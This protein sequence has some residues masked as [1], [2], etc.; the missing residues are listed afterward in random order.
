M[1]AGARFK[2]GVARRL[3]GSNVSDAALNKVRDNCSPVGTRRKSTY[4]DRAQL[5]VAETGSAG[6]GTWVT[7][8]A[9]V[10]ADFAKAFG[11]WPGTPIQIAVASDTDKSENMARA[12]FADLWFVTSRQLAYNG[13]HGDIE[14]VDGALNGRLWVPK[15]H[16]LNRQR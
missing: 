2:L 1:S 5:I 12:A 3:F 11:N 15:E 16:K 9:D 6:A 7:G 8:R 4:T 10:A 13:V 14:K